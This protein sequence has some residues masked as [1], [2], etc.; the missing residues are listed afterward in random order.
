MRHGE[1]QIQIDKP[2]A[3]ANHC[4]AHRKGGTRGAL[5]PPPPICVIIHAK[6]SNNIATEGILS[7][8]L[9]SWFYSVQCSL[10][11]CPMDE[12]F[13]RKSTPL[14]KVCLRPWAVYMEGHL[15]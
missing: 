5:A 13:L 9:T 11:S 14:L 4:Q 1:S 10:L 15:F 8:D 2:L 7:A 3:I 12:L 6:V